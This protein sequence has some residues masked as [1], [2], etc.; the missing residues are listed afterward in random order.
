MTMLRNCM[1]VLRSRELSFVKVR[2][3]LNVMSQQ[4]TSERE[5]TC[6]C[7]MPVAVVRTIASQDI[8]TR[9]TTDKLRSRSL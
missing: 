5:M 2:M 3:E 8:G 1:S 4:Q 7:S 6:A 9:P